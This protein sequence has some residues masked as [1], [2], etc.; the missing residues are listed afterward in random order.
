MFLGFFLLL[1]HC[2]YNNKVLDFLDLFFL[3]LAHFFVLIEFVKD[4]VVHFLLRSLDVNAFVN[5]RALTSRVHRFLDLPLELTCFPP[6]ILLQPLYSQ[7]PCHFALYI[8]VP[9][10]CLPHSSKLVSVVPDGVH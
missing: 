4:L 8:L 2:V 5:W 1:L 7:T 6:G 10:G 9:F 3:S